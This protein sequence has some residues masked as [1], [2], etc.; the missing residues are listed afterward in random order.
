L[1]LAPNTVGTLVGELVEEGFLVCTRDLDDARVVR[2]HLR[3]KA[4]ARFGAWR[5]QGGHI[6]D[7]AL[8]SLTPRERAQLVRALP[9][10]AQLT[11]ALEGLE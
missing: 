1:R 2:L 4:R 11:A 7:D 10:L 9:A 8:A 3:S 6:L 5:D